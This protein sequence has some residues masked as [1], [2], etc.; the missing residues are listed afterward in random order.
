MLCCKCDSREGTEVWC[1]GSIAY[2]HGMYQNWCKIC[3]VET[4]LAYAKERAAAIPELV[5]ELRR[6]RAEEAGEK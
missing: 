2:V 4:Q 1:E 6:L 5:S 3:V